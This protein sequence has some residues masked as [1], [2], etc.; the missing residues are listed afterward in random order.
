MNLVPNWFYLH[1]LLTDI[2]S[3]KWGP[4][5]NKIPYIFNDIYVV[6]HEKSF[7]KSKAYAEKSMFLV[8][9]LTF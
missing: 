2:S 5:K 8:I 1:V 4:W 7:F 9:S 6:C 3:G